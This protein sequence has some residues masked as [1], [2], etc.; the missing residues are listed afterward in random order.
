[1]K[2]KPSSIVFALLLTA[3][4]L[5]QPGGSLLNAS[6]EAPTISAVHSIT[7][8]P[9]LSALI[10]PIGAS[11]NPSSWAAEDVSTAIEAGL[12]PQALQSQYTQATTRAEFCALAVTLY[13]T[14]TGEVITDRSTFSDTDDVNVEKAAAI[15]V[16]NGVGNNLFSPDTQ[17]TREQAATMLSRLADALENPL[18]EHEATFND[19]ESI[20]IW[21]F[22]AV[23]QMQVTEI[24][25]GVGNNTFA[26]KSPYT[27]EQSILTILRLYYVLEPD[28][29]PD[30][31]TPESNDSNG[32]DLTGTFDPTLPDNEDLSDYFNSLPEPDKDEVP[33]E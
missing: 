24:M 19:N 33:K 27:R 5:L 18:P 8:Q 6:A 22:E 14:V 11:D 32:E 16:V 28:A 20:S 15:D 26:P 1:M 9:Q 21:A 25:A 3:V 23:G 29:S 2:N 17:L 4:L 30:S 13:E 10:V 12:V 7:E 31:D